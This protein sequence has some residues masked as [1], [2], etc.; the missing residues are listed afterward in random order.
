MTDTSYLPSEVVAALES[1][2]TVEAIKLLREIR[3]LGLAEANSAVNQY[4]AR[5]KATSSGTPSDGPLPPQ[6][7]DA[8]QGG[9]KIEAIRRVRELRGL[10]LREAKQAVD[11]WEAGNVGNVAAGKGLAP[12]EQKRSSSLLWLVVLA[13]LVAYALYRIFGAGG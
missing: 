5:M 6:A 10:D 3:G 4:L 8:L 2:R 11:A 13:V 7:I 1:G 9:N 12:G